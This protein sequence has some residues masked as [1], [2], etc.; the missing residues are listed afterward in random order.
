MALAKHSPLGASVS[1]SVQTN[2]LNG[3]L[4]VKVH[5]LYFGVSFFEG[6]ELVKLQRI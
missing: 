1:I 6:I 3:K 2:E 4:Q 5:T